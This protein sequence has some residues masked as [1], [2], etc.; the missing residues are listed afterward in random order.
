MKS[1]GES[2]MFEID[3]YKEKR[4]LIAYYFC[5]NEEVTITPESMYHVWITRWKN[6]FTQDG[7]LIYRVENG[8]FVE[9]IKDKD[10]LNECNIKI[11]QTYSWIKT[12]LEKYSTKMN[13]KRRINQ[14]RRKQL[15]TL[16]KVAKESHYGSIL[17]TKE[18]SN[19]KGLATYKII[20]KGFSK[21]GN[22]TVLL[23]YLNN[24]M[25]KNKK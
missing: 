22:Y 17:L 21:T 10:I 6:D 15:H 2:R 13:V 5:E 3:C 9:E 19:L 16:K 20:G 7:K 11:Q 12:H 1:E 25:R 4:L 18:N 24:I 14:Q 8:Q 23:K